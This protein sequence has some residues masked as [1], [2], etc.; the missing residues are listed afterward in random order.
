MK[1]SEIKSKL[2]EMDALHFELE[3][4]IAVPE[5]FHI[6]E[7]GIIER[8]FIDCGGALRKEK[9]INFQLWEANDFEHRLKPQKLLN[10]I[11]LSEKVLN[12]TDE[13]VEAEYQGET[14]GRYDITVEGN[15]FILHNKFTNCLAQDT[16][17][18]PQEKIKINIGQPQTTANT[19]K[20]GGGCC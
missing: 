14:I 2:T 18:I 6:T 8:N 3:N 1:L 11:Q 7:V 19:C 12:I 13:E 20:P 16:C 5:H 17:G 15:K 9:F 10:I 4:G